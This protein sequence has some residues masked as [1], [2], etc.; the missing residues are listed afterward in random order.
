MLPSK[1]LFFTQWTN[2]GFFRLSFLDYDFYGYNDYQ[3]GYSDP[4]FEDF[5]RYEDYYY[6]YSPQ[7]IGGGRSRTKTM[8][9]VGHF[10]WV[11]LLLPLLLFLIPPFY[12]G[13]PFSWLDAERFLFFYLGGRSRSDGVVERLE[14]VL[15]DGLKGFC[16]FFLR[17]FSKKQKKFSRYMNCFFY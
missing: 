8:S 13:T 15:N 14:R 16:F 10:S 9:L 5:Y 17:P 7:A 6:D 2:H 11:G 1:I 4:Y 3:G 12:L